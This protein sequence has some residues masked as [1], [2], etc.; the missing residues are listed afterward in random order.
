MSLELKTNY[1]PIEASHRSWSRQWTPHR[2]NG[3]GEPEGQGGE[4]GCKSC[5]PKAAAEHTAR[6]F[7]ISVSQWAIGWPIQCVKN[8]V[9]ASSTWSPCAGDRHSCHELV[10][11]NGSYR[12]TSVWW[13]APPPLLSPPG[14]RS[15]LIGTHNNL[16][17]RQK[18]HLHYSAPTGS[19]FKQAS[20]SLQQA[21]AVYIQCRRSTI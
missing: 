14:C 4:R 3:L 16:R 11:L 2:G 15:G 10:T 6:S 12:H 5:G 8:K 19:S 20:A 1:N 21:L 13:G 18:C 9:D 17:P 7:L